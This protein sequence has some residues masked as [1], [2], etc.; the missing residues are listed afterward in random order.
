MD[1]KA[2]PPCDLPLERPQLIRHDTK[3]W[4]APDISSD[5]D[6]FI[7]VGQDSDDDATQPYDVPVAPATVEKPG[8]VGA[9]RLSINGHALA[10]SSAISDQEPPSSGSST[11]K[12]VSSLLEPLAPFSPTMP[13]VPTRC[14]TP[15]L[16]L[17]ADSP[18]GSISSS[19][20]S[21]TSSTSAT[22]SSRPVYLPPTRRSKRLSGA[23]YP[24]TSISTS[25]TVPLK[26]TPLA[27]SQASAI[28][29]ASA[30]SSSKSRRRS[31]K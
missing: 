13:S 20:P 2:P 7:Q 17:E 30:L 4:P 31:P 22:A 21:T 26:A 15:A 28:D 25:T 12:S 10:P 11:L 29:A 19:L 5:E 3:L 23:S 16:Q 24:K 14:M 8:S 6:A 1:F 18:K 9:V 27:R